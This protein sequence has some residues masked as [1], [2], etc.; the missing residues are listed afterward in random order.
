MLY[1]PLVEQYY[2]RFYTALIVVLQVQNRIMHHDEHKD[3]QRPLLIL[4][5]SPA[6]L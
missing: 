1:D 2:D 5:S 4:R 6:L 3:F